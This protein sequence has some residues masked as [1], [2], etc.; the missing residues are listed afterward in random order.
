MRPLFFSWAVP[1]MTARIPRHLGRA[2]SSRKVVVPLAAAMALLPPLLVG[3]ERPAPSDYWTGGSNKVPSGQ[4]EKLMAEGTRANLAG[5]PSEA[6]A[7]FRSA[8]SEQ[9]RVHGN[10]SP[11]LALPLMSLALQLSGEGQYPQ[12]EAQFAE[13]ERVLRPSKERALKARLLHYRGVDKLIQKHPGE[14]EPLL[15]AAQVAYTALIPEDALTRAPQSKPVRNHFDVNGSVNIGA[16]SGV[17]LGG[18]DPGVQPALL[19]LIEVLRYRAIALRDLGRIAEAEPLTAYAARVAAANDLGRASVFARVYRTSGVTAAQESLQARALSDFSRSDDAFESALPGTKPAADAALIHAGELMRAGKSGAALSLCRRAVKTLV[20]IGQGT[21]PELMAPCLDAYASGG[22]FGISGNRSEMF[23]AAQV[24]QG[25]I[26][27]HQIA[28]ASAALSE[29]KRN[30]EI[31]EALRKRDD[32][33]RE[34]D[35]IYRALDTIGAGSSGRASEQVASLQQ[36]ADQKQAALTQAEAAVRALSPNYAQLVQD[37]VPASDVFAAM[38]PNEAFVALFVSKDSGWAFALRNGDIAIS[39]IDGGIAKVGPLVTAIRAGIEKTQV[40]ALPTFD[41]D[42]SRHLYDITIGGV[43]GKIRGATSLVIAP[44]GPLL[45]LPFEVLLTGPADPAKLASAPWLVRQATITHVPAATNFV[46]LRKVANTSRATKQWFGFGDFHPVNLAQAQ[47][48]FPVG[49]CGEN[50]R[51]LASLPALPGAV[52]ELETARGVLNASPTD[53]LLGDSFTA[54]QVLN[55]PLKD[56]K[57]LHF[58][59]HALLPT[60]LRCQTEAA[61]VTSPPKGAP[62]AKGALLTASELLGLDLDANLVI[63]SACNSGGPGGGAGE[64]LS[65]LARSFFFARARSL[66]VTHWEV[67]DQVAALLVVLTINDMKENPSH[68]VTG[69]L[70]DAQLKLLDKAQNGQLPAEIGHPFFWAPFAVIGDGGEGTAKGTV[71]SS[72]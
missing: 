16:S 27:S 50:G 23:L 41:I 18:A 11:L 4:F 10:D 47:R 61:I 42:D 14:A 12:A 15:G 53:A 1:L 35:R 32:L 55:R 33:Q 30:P 46:S 67:S 25:S 37:V 22:T 62:D 6:E 56:Y 29:S 34:V 48:S 44:T 65:G 57:V 19:G 64:S 39:K 24:A 2:I 45:S 69:A 21:S 49:P 8:L 72:L 31:G 5:R 40:N 38:R 58:A 70:R 68:G 60:D 3:C 26:T 51:Q 71:S 66:L 63:L 36:Q 43:A 54:D 17:K 59:A 20:S 28:Q 9:R 13:A 7:R 52:K